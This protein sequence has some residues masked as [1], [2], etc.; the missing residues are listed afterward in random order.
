MTV[1]LGKC[2]AR[3]SLQTTT[4]PHRNQ[5]AK[6]GSENRFW[7]LPY[8]AVKSN[9]SQTIWAGAPCCSWGLIVRQLKQRWANGKRWDCL[10]QFVQSGWLL[11]RKWQAKMRKIWNLRIPWIQWKPNYCMWLR[12]KCE[13]LNRSRIWRRYKRKFL[14]HI[15]FSCLTYSGQGEPQLH[16]AG[17]QC[18]QKR[19][20]DEFSNSQKRA[21]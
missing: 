7:R 16:L 5:R 12:T 8:V 9:G 1:R 14:V 4:F 21:F 2:R 15:I 18:S 19:N 10:W 11:N 20:E 6:D 3:Q 13:L 17:L